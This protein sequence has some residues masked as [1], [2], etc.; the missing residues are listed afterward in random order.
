M[1]TEITQHSQFPIVVNAFDLEVTPPDS[2]IV[3]DAAQ[4]IATECKTT[5]D[6]VYYVAL[7]AA[8][9]SQEEAD[10]IVADTVTIDWFLA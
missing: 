8:V 7:C 4:Q 5:M 10:S 6:Q 9:G 2:S 3:M 1:S